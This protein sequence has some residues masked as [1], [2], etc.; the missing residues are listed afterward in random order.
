MS[1]STRLLSQFQGCIDEFISNRSPILS[2]I[3]PDATPLLEYSRDFLRGG[4]RFRALFTYWAWQGI[5]EHR[6]AN[7]FVGA[8]H[9]D[10][11][12]NA[13][14]IG[15]AWSD[16]PPDAGQDHAAVVQVASALELFHAAA[17]VHDDVIDNSDTRRGTPAAHKRFENAH[18]SGEWRGNPAEFGVASAILLGDLLQFW[19]DELFSDGVLELKD[20]KAARAARA[21]F[22]RM[23][24]EVGVGQY[25]DVLE[26]QIWGNASDTEQ[27]ERS[28]RVLT[29]KSAKYSVEAPLLI[30]A[31]LAGATPEQEAGLSEFGLPLGIAFQL[32]DDVLGVFG[33]ST[34]T[35]K[36]SGDDLR[37]GKQTVLIALARRAL[38][39]NQRRLFDEL[40]GDPEL[41]NTQITLLQNTIT[42]TGALELVEKMIAENVSRA[43]QALLDAPIGPVTA[44]QLRALA[45]RVTNR[46]F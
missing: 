28:T 26:E 23:R 7:P 37:E 15:A 33:D 41:D 13:D 10:S 25:L 1:H 44:R 6:E 40:I 32:R 14:A 19:S 30:G 39:G 36:P 2:E 12:N 45:N 4:K 43:Q 29:Y 20:Q 46:A 31:A 18:T 17:L 42:E 24:T 8:S 27:L 22:N 21:H 35:G 5:I 11:V 38:P 34:V 3:G 16:I 9:S